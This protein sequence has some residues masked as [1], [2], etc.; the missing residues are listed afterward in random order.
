MLLRLTLKRLT[1]DALI[2][3]ARFS[4]IVSAVMTRALALNAKLRYCWKLKH[5]MYNC[6]KFLK[7]N[8][9]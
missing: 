8:N 9:V 5:E 3:A 7:G 4:I 2:T 6:K 1:D